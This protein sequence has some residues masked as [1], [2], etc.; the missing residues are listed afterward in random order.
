VRTPCKKTILPVP[1]GASRWPRRRPSR[2]S[3]HTLSLDR[4]VRGVLQPGRSPRSTLVASCGTGSEI[5]LV[6]RAQGSV[7]DG[8]GDVNV[9]GSLVTLARNGWLEVEHTVG[10]IRIRLGRRAKELRSQEERRTG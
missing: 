1:F 2:R 9:Q 5:K 6:N 8:N 3:R 4:I 10:E 7:H